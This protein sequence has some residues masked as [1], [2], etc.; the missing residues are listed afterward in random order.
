MVASG[1]LCIHYPS[2][3]PETGRES[4]V[5][6]A[7]AAAERETDRLL[8]HLLSTGLYLGDRGHYLAGNRQGNKRLVYR[9]SL[10]APADDG[11]ARADGL[12]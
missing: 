12:S 7:W 1:Y 6:M 9:L 2:H 8:L 11:T 10:Y 5:P 3:R 4:K